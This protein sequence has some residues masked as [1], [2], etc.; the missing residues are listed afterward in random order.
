M[1]F[2]L[3]A[4]IL[5]LTVSCTGS[6]TGSEHALTKEEL[7]DPQACKD[8]HP[9]HFEE[10]EGSMHAYASADPVFRA[11][12]ARGQ[13]ETN[14]ELGDFCVQCHAP[15]AVKLGLTTDGLN[16]DE[17]PE[18]AKGVTCFFCHSVDAIEGDHNAPV[19]LADDLVMRGGFDDPVDNPAHQSGY[20]K[21]LDRKQIESA[22][23]C[24][25][26]HD[27][28]TPAGVHLERTF[29][30]WKTSL[31]SHA[32]PGEQQTCGDCHMQGRDDVAAD[33]DG[34]LLRQAHSHRMVG[35]DTALI[36]FP[37]T[38]EQTKQVQRDLDRAV[39]AQ[40]CVQRQL[41]DDTLVTVTLENLAA[42][43]SFPS[44]ATHDRRVWME[45]IAYDEADKIVYQ[46]GVLEDGK[47]LS[48]LED[49]DL[50]RFGSTA[51]DTEGKKVHM[52]WDI[53]TLEGDL[54]PAPTANDPE[55]PE[56]TDTHRERVYRLKGVYDPTRVTVR[57]RIR[58]LGL[59]LIEDLV[60]SGDLQ[61]DSLS[62]VP[63]FDL[64]FS[65]LEWRAVDGKKCVP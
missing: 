63:T 21:F 62:T 25:S 55:D 60:D 1:K 50:W 33:F 54:L 18:Y 15:M 46:S 36:P 51:Y 6:D 40:F 37:D 49:P 20:S 7:M 59:D 3:L 9:K 26:C 65:V 22:S 45:V 31:Y 43:H 5:A 57:L 17:L 56:Y 39:F 27:I 47:P 2:V 23:F 35:V 14:G 52:P 13:R 10:W 61:P 24:G 12:N 11:M 53:A 30:E 38:D 8:C 42:G 44:G 58:A 64:G 28:V 16:L 19:R 41:E 32:V 29:A 34:V 4:S 48:S